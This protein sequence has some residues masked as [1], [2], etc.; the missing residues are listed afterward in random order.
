MVQYGFEFKYLQNL[1]DDELC[2]RAGCGFQNITNAYDGVWCGSIVYFHTPKL[3]LS[4]QQSR[5]V[6]KYSNK[7]YKK[8]N[9]AANFGK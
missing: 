6:M 9:I 2:I 3:D 7:I 8:R 5:F 4:S 1:S